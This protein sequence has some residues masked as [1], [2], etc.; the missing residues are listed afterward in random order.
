MGNIYIPPNLS[1]EE[2]GLIFNVIGDSS[3]FNNVCR[4]GDLNYRNIDW[5]NCT[6]IGEDKA[7]AFINM[8]QDTFLYQLVN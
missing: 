2:S 6:S 7:E 3:K 8:I 5:T 1:L 4:M